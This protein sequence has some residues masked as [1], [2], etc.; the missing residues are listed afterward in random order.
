MITKSSGKNLK[1]P[2]ILLEV[3]H[4]LL[5]I[6]ER[7][8]I[9]ISMKRPRTIITL[10]LQQLERDPVRKLIY[11]LVH[12]HSAENKIKPKATNNNTLR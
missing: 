4:P 2:W 7:L 11:F 5:F 8:I 1:N 3:L 9:M 10:S 12:K 6:L